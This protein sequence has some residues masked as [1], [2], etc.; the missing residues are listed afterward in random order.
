MQP[1]PPFMVLVLAIFTVFAVQDLPAQQPAAPQSPGYRIMLRS[2]SPPFQI[3]TPD[4]PKRTNWFVDPSGDD[5]A[6]RTF[7]DERRFEAKSFAKKKIPDPTAGELD[8]SELTV[9]DHKTKKVFILVLK[10]EYLFTE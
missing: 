6:L 9:V 7:G 1:K 2:T 3:S 4:E 5:R 8:V 10:K